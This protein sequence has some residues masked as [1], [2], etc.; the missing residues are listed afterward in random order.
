MVFSRAAATKALATIGLN[1]TPCRVDITVTPA[2][3][4]QFSFRANALQQAVDTLPLSQKGGL[5]LIE[6]ETGWGKTEA[7]LRFFTRLWCEG[8]VDGL[9]FAN[10][11]RFAATQLFGRVTRFVANT[12]GD[13]P[14]ST[15][16]AVPGYLR[17]DGVCGTMLPGFEVQWDDAPDRPAAER[18][19]AAEHPKRFLAAPLAV[20]TIDQA[21]LGTL[22]VR[23]AH[24]RTAALC[25]SLLVVD[26]VH[27]SDTY[28]TRLTLGLL[29]FFR[30]AGGQVLLLS[31]TLGGHVRQQYLNGFQGGRLRPSLAQCLEAPYPAITTVAGML[32]VTDD[33]PPEARKKPVRVLPLTIQDAPETVA[34]LTVACVAQ[35]GRVL[36]LRNAVATARE[37]QA[38]L[39]AL[40][41]PERLFSVAGAACPHHARYARSD[42]QQLDTEVE[43]R[44]G[45]HGDCQAGVLVATQT[46]EQSLDVDFDV[47]I[48]DLCPMDVLLQRLGRLHRHRDRDPSRPAG[49]ALPVCHLLTPKTFGAD[50]LRAARRHQYG[51]ERAYENL[52]AVLATWERILALDADQKVLRIP[53]MSRDLVERALHPEIM[54]DVAKRHGM[55]QEFKDLIGRQG[56]R[57]QNARLASIDWGKP[58][59]ESAGTREGLTVGTRLGL[60]DRAVRFASP[61]GSPFGNAVEEL[62]VPQW[63]APESPEEIEPEVLEASPL[64]F[65]FR[66]QRFV[67]RYDRYGLSKEAS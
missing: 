46:L 56:A 22:R 60:R 26:E 20:G 45:R 11:L 53:E 39:E 3:D 10:P 13:A 65:R 67:Y 55:Q 2:F 21:L 15:V 25:R 32:P 8:L 27:A 19:W 52:L 14:P 30:R 33:R 43:N 12:F 50:G 31:A 63:M 42:R 5:T 16:L 35:G 4:H 17:V 59:T 18:R 41:P 61:L 34:E 36:V 54:A 62:T 58:F 1:A 57:G 47:L 40:L 48:T 38:A 24:L 23:H 44:F 6:A 28:M 64:G 29:D 51:K 49:H 7:A 66:L 9:Y 37:T